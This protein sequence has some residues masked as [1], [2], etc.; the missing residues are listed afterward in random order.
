[1]PHLSQCLCSRVSPLH[2]ALALYND[3]V[4]WYRL[5]APP[6]T[7]LRVLFEQS[8]TYTTNT[9]ISH[10][11]DVLDMVTIYSIC[12]LNILMT[13]L[14]ITATQMHLLVEVL[15]VSEIPP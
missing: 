6:H 11:F 2:S 10:I 13:Y 4:S 12:I 9:C 5:W 7:L 8:C 14:C 1:M 3:D 15:M